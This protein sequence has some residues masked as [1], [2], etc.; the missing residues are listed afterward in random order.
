MLRPNLLFTRHLFAGVPPPKDD[1][2]PPSSF[3]PASISSTLSGTLPG[4]TAAAL[5]ATVGAV[6]ADFLGT[7]MLLA[8]GIE[9]ASSPISGIPLA[10]LIGVGANSLLPLSTLNLS[11]GLKLCSTSVLRCGIVLVGLKL[12]FVDVASM[13]AALPA[14]VCCMGV[15]Y[16]TAKTLGNAL[17]LP[18]KMSSLIAAGTTICGVTAITSVAGAI[19]ASKQDMSFAVANVVA[20]GTAGMLLYPHLAPHLFATSE[21]IGMWV[22]LAIHDTSQVMGAA[23][24]YSEVHA[25][26]VVLRMAAVTKLTRN[27]FLAAAVPY[28]SMLHAPRD[29]QLATSQTTA[30]SLA[31]NVW[32]YTPGFV[33]MFIGAACVRSGGDALFADPSLTLFGLTEPDWQ[34][35]V[36]RASGWSSPLLCV[37]MA[38]VGLQTSP[39]ALRGVGV[40][41]FVVGLAASSAVAVT[42]LAAITA[43]HATGVM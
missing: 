25:D 11:R 39:K 43:L 3:L 15:G 22:G 32:K 36:A 17:G 14:I 24:T 41:P 20:F 8:Q 40:K 12:S 34:A 5:V 21:Q 16:V 4:F 29:D 6:S 19:K 30:M 33:L 26:E 27:L 7:Q 1:K 28:F 37:A 31:K 35:A 9:G 18:P 2:T 13:S 23:L 42:G 38:G 10:I